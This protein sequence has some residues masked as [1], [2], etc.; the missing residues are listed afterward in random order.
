MLG[1]GITP[2]DREAL[3]K[4]VRASREGEQAQAA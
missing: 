2:S 4:N 1:V 3:L